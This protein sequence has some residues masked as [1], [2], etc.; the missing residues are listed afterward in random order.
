MQHTQQTVHTLTDAQAGEI[1]DLAIVFMYDR[2]VCAALGVN[3]TT[4]SQQEQEK[5][6]HY[7]ANIVLNYK[8]R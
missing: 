6:Y 2:G 4:L 5:I 1:S 8:K 3:Y 7:A